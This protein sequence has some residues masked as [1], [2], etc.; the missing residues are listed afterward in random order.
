MAKEKTIKAI[1]VVPVSNGFL[2]NTQEST[3]PNI[4]PKL[5]QIYFETAA[6]ACRAGA[7]FLEPNV[8]HIVTGGN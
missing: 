5:E 1:Q 2:L 8:V 7:E 4:P 6:E 3:T